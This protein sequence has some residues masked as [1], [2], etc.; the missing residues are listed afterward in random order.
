MSEIA[1][2][3]R[4]LDVL[5]KVITRAESI[6]SHKAGK[7][8]GT[9]VLLYRAEIHTIKTIG[10]KRGINITRL[11]EHMGVTK[12]AVSQTVNKLVRKRL[13]R[14]THAP[15]NAKELLLELT[16]LGWTGYHNH[17]KFH[18][19]MFGAVHEYYGDKLIPNIEILIKAVEDLNCIIDRLENREQGD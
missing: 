9:G 15:D 17:E 16:D 2:F 10:D 11:A 14:K 4:F 13:V 5:D 18:M 3:E 7:D 6:Q 12:G 19:E 1:V 8:F